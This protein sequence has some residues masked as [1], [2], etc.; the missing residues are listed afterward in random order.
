MHKIIYVAFAKSN[1]DLTEKM[2][3]FL[4]INEE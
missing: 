1:E 2:L 4:G 3:E